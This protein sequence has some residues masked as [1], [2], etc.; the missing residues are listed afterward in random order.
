MEGES[1]I[2]KSRNLNQE[3]LKSRREKLAAELDGY[4]KQIEEYLQNGDYSEINKY[5]KSAQKLQS[6]L[7]SVSERIS[8]FNHEETLFEWEP[9]KFTSLQTAFDSLSPFLTLYQTSVDLQKCYQNWMNGPFLKLEA[10]TVEAEVTTMWRNIYKI[11]L[12]F[13]ESPIP[14]ELAEITKQQIEKFKAYL[15][16]ITTLCNPGFKDRHWKDISQVVGFRFQPDEN[17]SL[18]QVVERNLGQYMAKLEEISAIATKE[19]SFE[20]ALQKM[21][22]EWKDV[23]FSTHDYRDTGT[24]ILGGVDD[25]QTL[26]DD[27][28]VKTQTMRGS[29]YIKAFEDESKTWDQKLTL[30]QEILDEWLKV[31]II[32]F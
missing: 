29:P 24:Q 12:A 13:S 30:I 4:A 10:E 7:E 17:T 2:T 25:I 8:I 11:G 9:T 19:F 22:Q 23:E 16:L 18:S 20:K 27:H 6:R 5:L 31:P 14:M 28:I 1:N 3:D 32:L 15:P 21:F 26:L